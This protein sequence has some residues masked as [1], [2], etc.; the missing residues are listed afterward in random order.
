MMTVAELKEMLQ[1][2]WGFPLEFYLH[3]IYNQHEYAGCFDTWGNLKSLCDQPDK[4]GLYTDDPDYC[5]DDVPEN[6]Q[7]DMHYILDHPYEFNWW[8][9]DIKYQIA[10]LRD[11]IA[12]LQGMI[13]ALNNYMHE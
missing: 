8:F 11:S 4:G 9:A 10:D 1:P 12:A 13:D 3:T 6:I 2:V 5:M 7:K